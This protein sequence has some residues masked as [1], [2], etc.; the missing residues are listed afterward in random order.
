MRRVRY[1]SAV[2]DTTL[3]CLIATAFPVGDAATLFLQ[4]LPTIADIC[5]LV[6]LSNVAPQ[7]RERE[8]RI[9]YGEELET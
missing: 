7:S 1:L 6:C 5:V 8:K 3:L 4:A 9:Y 2:A